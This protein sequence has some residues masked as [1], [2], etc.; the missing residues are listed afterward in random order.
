VGESVTTLGG[1][2]TYGTIAG[3]KVVIGIAVLD[4]AN[5]SAV[6]DDF[7]KSMDILLR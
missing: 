4:T 7:T 5:V 1:H 6:F 2:L 3:I